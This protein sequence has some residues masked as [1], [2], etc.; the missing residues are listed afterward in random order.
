MKSFDLRSTIH[1]SKL[2]TTLTL[3]TVISAITYLKFVL[4]DVVLGDVGEESPSGLRETI[5]TAA[6][7]RRR[8]LRYV[9]IFLGLF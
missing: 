6:V 8:Q 5:T 4:G 1:S 7:D 9:L 2:I 3:S